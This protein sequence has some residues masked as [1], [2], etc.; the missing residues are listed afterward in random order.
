MRI[1]YIEDD[2][3]QA[4]DVAAMV[5]REGLVLDH[6]GNGAHGLKALGGGDY[7]VVLLDRMLPDMSGIDIVSKM[8]AAGSE[9]PVLMVSALG[10]SENRVEGL[11]AGV[12]D[13]L[14]KPFAADELLARL[15][16][17]HR[18]ASG[19]GSSAIILFGD[20]ECH[21]KARAAYR[22][23]KHIALSPKEFEL[24]RYFMQNGGEVVTRV[25]LLKDVWNLDFDPQTNVVDV[26]VG[27]LRR[28]LEQGFDSPVLETIWGS[29]YRLRAV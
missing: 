19:E 4:S 10:R 20:M 22:Q 5:E 27:R 12:D 1:L 15:R 23:G 14:A 26:N 21:V 7:D 2:S 25:M 6:A 29:G 13:Y 16:A 11:D 28:K 3:Q 17:L 18:R 8:R 9:V 24:F